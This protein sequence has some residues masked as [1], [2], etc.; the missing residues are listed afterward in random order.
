MNTILRFK[1]LY[2]EA[3]KDLTNKLFASYL[4]VLTWASLLL[5][6]VVAYAFIYRLFTGFAF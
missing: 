1:N 5:I 2:R 6:G 4:K 3:F